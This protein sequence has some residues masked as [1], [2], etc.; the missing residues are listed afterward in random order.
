M[1]GFRWRSWLGASVILFLLYGAVNVVAAP[2][3]PITLV[4][5]GAGATVLV[6]DADSDAYLVGGRGVI[7]IIGRRTLAR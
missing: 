3:A 7:L 6:I 4:R 5:G 2:V 1:N